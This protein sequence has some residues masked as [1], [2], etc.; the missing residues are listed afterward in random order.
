VLNRVPMAAVMRIPAVASCFAAVVA[1]SA[2]ICMLE[3][4]LPLF[5]ST[6]LGLGP[7]RI[8]FVFGTSAVVSAVLHPFFGRLADRSGGRRL[9][10]IGL[11]LIALVLPL[12]SRAWSYPSAIAFTRCRWRPWRVSSPRRSRIWP[13]L[14]PTGALDRFGVAYG[15]HT[16]RGVWACSADRRS[17]A[18]CSNEWVCRLALIWSP[19]LVIVT[20]LL[21]RVIE[22]G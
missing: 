8:G 1:V 20:V 21:A 11:V 13:R 3:P 9:T 19:V 10:I 6:R 4:V 12:L 16:W 18:S 7:A 17:A 15:L 14:F 2:T 5:L 22:A